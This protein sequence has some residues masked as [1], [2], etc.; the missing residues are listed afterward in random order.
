MTRLTQG[1]LMIWVISAST[2][3]LGRRVLPRARVPASSDSF[4]DALARVWPKPRDWAVC[5]VGEHHA[6]VGA[7]DLAAGLKRG[8]A[9]EPV[10]VDDA[11]VGGGTGEQVRAV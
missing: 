2:L 9:L 5:S 11:A 1:S 4:A 3:A 6:A 7:V 8:Q 10:G